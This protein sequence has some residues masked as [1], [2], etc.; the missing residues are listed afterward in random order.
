MDGFH[1]RYMA[2]NKALRAWVAMVRQLDIETIAPQHGAVF[3]GK[4]MVARF[5]D[6]CDGLEVGLD[7]LQPYQLPDA[8]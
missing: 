2:G 7:L 6:W 1:R 8:R 5:L 4:P 3:R